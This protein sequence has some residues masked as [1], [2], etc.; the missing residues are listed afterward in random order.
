MRLTKWRDFKKAKDAPTDWEG[1][2][3]KS[4]DE[5]RKLGMAAWNDPDKPTKDWPYL[6]LVLMLFPSNWYNAIPNGF[7][8]VNLF[9]DTSKFKYGVTS[10]DRR[11]GFLAF[12]ILVEVVDP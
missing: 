1:L 5:L 9:G 12:G 3:T 7:E 4:I 10:D 6:R 8:I 11:F 2:R